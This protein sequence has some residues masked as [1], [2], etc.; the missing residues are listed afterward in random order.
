MARRRSRARERELT[1]LLARGTDDHYLDPLLYDFEYGDQ[2][3]DVEWYCALVDARVPDRVELGG[4]GTVLELGA[5]SGRVTI[6]LA[7]GGHRILAL[8]RMEPMLEHLALKVRRLEQADYP[9][10]GEIEALVADMTAIPLAD[11]SVS[12]VVAPFNCL[13]HL[14]TWQELLACFREVARVLE[15]GGTFACDVLMPDLE[16]LQW[17]PNERHA[18]TPFEHP[19]TGRKMIYSTNHEY[20]HDTQVCH[21]R[22]YY[23]SA[24]G[25]RLRPRTT[26]DHVVH[27]AHR[28]IFPEELRMLVGVAGLK[29]ESHTGDF[30][31]LSLNEDIEAQALI[32]RKPVR[33]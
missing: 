31:D 5:G 13:M 20:D 30:L 8:D 17:D 27:L 1:T 2:T 14:Y 11:D 25:G 29:L 26:P 6:P 7:R 15:P 23:D 21:I 3:A 33:E 19:R 28:Q 4:S 16:W 22:I 9:I 10:E 32:A 12:L 18:V 24:K